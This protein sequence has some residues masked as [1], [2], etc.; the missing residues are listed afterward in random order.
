MELPQYYCRNGYP[1]RDMV[2]RLEKSMY[3]QMDSPKLFYEHLST[4]VTAL[5]F[6]PTLLDSCLS[7]HKTLPVMVLN[8]CDDQFG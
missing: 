3:G 8:Y 2:L 7:V 4:G 1:G 5:G 6:E